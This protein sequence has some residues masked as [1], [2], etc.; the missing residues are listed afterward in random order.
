M[1]AHLAILLAYHVKEMCASVRLDFIRLMESVH[2][3]PLLVESV[4]AE[5]AN[6]DYL[7]WMEESAMLVIHHA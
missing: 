6:L 3:V 4:L 1:L 2:C 7:I 5:S